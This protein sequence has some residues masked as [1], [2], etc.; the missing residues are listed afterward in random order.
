MS[1]G[2]LIVL[3]YVS[4]GVTAVGVWAKAKLQ[5]RPRLS[6]PATLLDRSEITL[7]SESVGLL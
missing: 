7:D 4:A 5:A 2:Q 6:P 1:I 3:G